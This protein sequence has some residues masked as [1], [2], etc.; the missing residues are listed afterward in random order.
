MIY[1]DLKQRELGIE[2]SG[3]LCIVCGWNEKNVDG[4]SLIE[5]AHVK[6]FLRDESIDKFDNIIS[7][8]P[9]HHTEFDAGNFYIKS[10]DN[11]IVFRNKNNVYHNKIIKGSIKH[12]RKEYLIYREYLFNNLTKK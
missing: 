6:P 12:I 3:N 2:K 11:K 1:R 10:D 9:N 5:G 4:K 8:C 7:L